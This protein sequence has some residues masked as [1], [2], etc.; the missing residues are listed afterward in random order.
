MEDLKTL[1]IGVLGG[2]MVLG[3]AKA[4]KSYRHK[5]VQED[6]KFLEFEKKHLGEMKKSSVEMNRSSFRAI[7]ALFLFIGLANLTPQI[8]D[9]INAEALSG[10]SSL[11]TMII[12]AM[13]IGLCIKFWRRY[14]NLKNFKEA[15]EKLDEKIEKL[16]GKLPE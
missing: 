15:M 12:W 7:F 4:Y 2:L 3:I 9:L 1:F 13:F 10:L 8:F 5:S 14:E 11:V 16:R 6:I